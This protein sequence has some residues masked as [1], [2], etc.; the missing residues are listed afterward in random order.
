MH[1]ILSLPVCNFWP[2][3]PSLQAV[4]DVGCFYA[5]LDVAWSACLSLQCGHMGESRKMT[6]P[7]EFA[8][9]GEDLCGP[10]EPYIIMGC[11]LAPLANA[12]ERSMLRGD[13]HC[14]LP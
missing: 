5:C 3:S 6:E 9:W 12:V 2:A 4:L 8:I 11:V 13:A 1:R 10:K 14:H 7:T